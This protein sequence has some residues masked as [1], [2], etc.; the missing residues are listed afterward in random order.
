MERGRI[1]FRITTG[2]I[3]LERFPD[4][5][6]DLS[7]PT[8]LV[9]AIHF[10]C[11]LTTRYFP[12]DRVEPGCIR[13]LERFPDRRIELSFS[14]ILVAAIYFPCLVTT[15]YFSFD[16]VDPGYIRNYPD[17][18]SQRAFRTL[19]LFSLHSPLVFL[20]NYLD[21]RA[22][23]FFVARGRGCFRNVSRLW[24]LDGTRITLDP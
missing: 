7:F 13:N 24:E 21:G 18:V 2:D 12:F 20:E 19:N 11:L 17:S 5:R 14:T 1:F 22:C 23:P 15:R 8:I 10:L 9:A 3:S 16:R 4:R 6:I